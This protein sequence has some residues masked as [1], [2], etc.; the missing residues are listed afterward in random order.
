[1]PQGVRYSCFTSSVWLVSHF[2]AGIVMS[3]SKSKLGP[4]HRT[5]PFHP[6]LSQL[7]NCLLSLS[8]AAPRLPV[9]DV[10]VTAGHRAAFGRLRGSKTLPDSR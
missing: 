7:F 9:G 2:V 1:M 4:T 3:R 10:I 5:V 8:F 6:L